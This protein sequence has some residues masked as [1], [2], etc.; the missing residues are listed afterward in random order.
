MSMQQH[1][2][3]AEQSRHVAARARYGARGDP[4]V[5]CTCSTTSTSSPTGESIIV[6]RVGGEL[7]LATVNSG[8]CVAFGV[9]CSFLPP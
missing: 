8:S 2:V 6:L 1:D 7:D 5:W 4:T 3:S 9:A